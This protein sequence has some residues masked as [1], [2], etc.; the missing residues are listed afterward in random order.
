MNVN[1][2]KILKSDLMRAERLTNLISLGS[3]DTLIIGMYYSEENDFQR[4]EMQSQKNIK[5]KNSFVFL[6]RWSLK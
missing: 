2:I 3:F 6:N 4:L 1:D 5:G